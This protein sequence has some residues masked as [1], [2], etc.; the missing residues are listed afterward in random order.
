MRIVFN[1]IGTG[2]GNNGGSFTL[3][4][5]ANT[6]YKLGHEVIIVDGGKNKFTWIP[7]KVKHTIV[8]DLKKFPESDVIIASGVGSFNSTNRLQTDAKKFV[9]LRGWEI[10]NVPEKVL[11]DKLLETKAIKIVNSICLQKKLN[12]FSIPSQLIRPGYDFDEIFPLDIRKSNT[13]VVLGGLF[14]QGKKRTS[15]RT[16]WIYSVY[17]FLRSKYANIE[18]LMFGSDGVPSYIE[19]FLKNPIMSKKN[20]LYNRCD[21][22]LAPS[23]LEGLHIAPAEAMLTECPVVSTSAEMSGTQ[24][25][26]FHKYNGYVSDN[27]FN[28][29]SRCVELLVIKQSLRIE[30]GKKARQ[31]VLELGDRESNMKKLVDILRGSNGKKEKC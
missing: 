8:H 28:D 13:S 7:L 26:L 21:V 20:E 18:L 23:E 15:K 25:Y 11:V 3:V 31:K 10:W 19:S 30:M 5:S 9:W 22:W 24:D 14:N 2:L 6:L 16:D 1:L 29:F 12:H 27:N 4:K 17:K